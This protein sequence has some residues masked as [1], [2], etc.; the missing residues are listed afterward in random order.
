MEEKQSEPWISGKKVKQEEMGTNTGLMT[1]EFK[2]GESRETI[3][4]E[5]SASWEVSEA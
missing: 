5:L 2:E 1:H 3:V 4:L